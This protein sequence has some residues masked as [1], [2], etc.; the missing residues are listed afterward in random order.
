MRPCPLALGPNNP[1]WLLILL[2]MLRPLGLTM[3]G[4]WDGRRL[5]R[6]RFREGLS[7][8]RL[9]LELL[10][11]SKYPPA[12]PEG[13]PEPPLPFPPLLLLLLLAPPP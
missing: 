9:L 3:G 10:E 1:F 2:F 5:T 6:L 7:D 8:L 12:A 4:D 13:F 11:L